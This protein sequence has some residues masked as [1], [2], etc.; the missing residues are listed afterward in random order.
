MDLTTCVKIGKEIVLPERGGGGKGVRSNTSG[1]W[2]K[3]R[4]EYKGVLFGK[5]KVTWEVTCTEVPEE[6]RKV[7][8][9]RWIFR[10]DCDD[11]CN[12]CRR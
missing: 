2:G 3:V 6:K 9:F 4:P 10:N 12:R 5:C 1:S 8:M 11:R 7:N